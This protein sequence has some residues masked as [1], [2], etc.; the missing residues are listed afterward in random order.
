ML[1]MSL[2]R[3]PLLIKFGWSFSCSQMQ[4]AAGSLGSSRLLVD[5]ACNLG[6]DYLRLPLRMGPTSVLFS[7]GGVFFV[8]AF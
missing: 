7:R 6:G 5:L 3:T 8:A 4:T 2:F 1:D